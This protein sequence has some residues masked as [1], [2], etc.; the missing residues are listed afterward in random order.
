[1]WASVSA[2]TVGYEGWSFSFSFF[3]IFYREGEVLSAEVKINVVELGLTLQEEKLNVAGIL[4]AIDLSVGG[5][6]NDRIKTRCKIADSCSKVQHRSYERRGTRAY[7]F[8]NTDPLISTKQVE[9]YLSIAYI[10]DDVPTAF[11]RPLSS[12]LTATNNTIGYVR[13]Y[14][15]TRQNTKKGK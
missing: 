14:V 13:T 8:T 9:I 6:R 11:V 10:R 3:L 2:R 1:M 15:H 4:R 5:A 12:R 7:V